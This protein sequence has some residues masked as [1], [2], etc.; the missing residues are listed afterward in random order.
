M[1]MGAKTPAKTSTQAPIFILSPCLTIWRPGTVP[2][3]GRGG[4]APRP[5]LP[6]APPAAR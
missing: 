6:E 3:G 4:S 5:K 2:S 1:K